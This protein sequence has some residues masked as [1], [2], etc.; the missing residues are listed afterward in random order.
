MAFDQNITYRVNVDDSDFQAKL[1]QLR[2]SLDMTMG[3]SMM[4]GM[5]GMG[6]MGGAGFTGMM[7][8][9]AAFGAMMAPQGGGYGGGSGLADFGSQIRPITYTPP[10][11]AMQPHFGMVAL[12]QTTGQAMFGAMGPLGLGIQ[13][14][15]HFARH[16][17][18]S[19]PD[20]IP[21]NMSMGEYAA[22]ST[23]AFA[24]RMGD[25]VSTAGVVTAGTAASM[26][27]SGLGSAIGGKLIGGF[28]GELIGGMVGGAAVGALVSSTGE[29]MADNRRTQT[30]LEAGSFRFITGGKDADPLTGRGFSRAAR[31]EAAD[32]IQSRELQD[33]R[34][35]MGE[36]SQILESGMQ[37][38][39]FSGSSDLQGFKQ[40]FNGLV[41]SI[42]TVTSTLHTSLKEGMEVIRGFRDIGVTDPGQ[43]SG[44]VLKAETIG[45][46]SGRTGSEML[47]LGQAGAETFRGTGVSMALGMETNMQNVGLV[48][49]MLNMGT[50]NRDTVA[51]A[52][53]ENA[54]A[55]Q[56]TASALAATQSAVGRGA[57]LGMF[58]PATGSLDMNF[59]GGTFGLLGRA[60]SKSPTDI[61]NFQAQEEEIVSKMSPMQL[62]T[63]G[64]Q[65][66]LMQAKTVTDAF[67]GGRRGT[68]EYQQALE[69]QFVN[70]EKR[71]G[72]P[73]AAIRANVGFLHSDPEKIMESQEA[74][75]ASMAQ[76]ASLEDL[77][78]N[79]NIG[80]SIENFMGRTFVQPL[81]RTFTNIG[82]KVAIDIERLGQTMMGATVASPLGAGRASIAAGRA[83]IEASG[84]VEAATRGT[85]LGVIDSSGNMIQR[86]LPGGGQ[87]GEGLA[88]E[89]AD[90]GTEGK[91]VVGPTGQTI[92][93]STYQ[94]MTAMRFK[95]VEDVQ[96][97]NKETGQQMQILSQ[98][99]KGDNPVV[100][101]QT[102]QLDEA[103]RQQDRT[104]STSADRTKAEES[105]LTD[106]QR[107]MVEK[108]HQ[109]RGQKAGFQTLGEALFGKDQFWKDEKTAGFQRAMIERVAKEEGFDVALQ[110]AQGVRSLGGAQIGAAASLFDAAHGELA[111]AKKIL[112]GYHLG[113]SSSGA[114]VTG[115]VLS[116][117]SEAQQL[118]AL[119]M[120]VTDDD[121]QKTLL[122][123]ELRH[124]GVTQSQ[125]DLFD[126]QATASIKGEQRKELDAR[127]KNI[128]LSNALAQD[129]KNEAMG[130]G[131]MMDKVKGFFSTE[132]GAM[133]S[134]SPEQAKQ[135]GDLANQ[136]LE[137]MKLV[138]EL[139]K[140]VRDNMPRR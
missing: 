115:G 4:S 132:S 65:V 134:G 118:T 26:V 120:T 75:M 72:V 49:Q 130:F 68:P 129:K 1:S 69:N 54:L 62:Q 50:I 110:Q 138:V 21:Q 12:Q 104:Q 95:S 45:R 3:G 87:S 74:G 84:G 119:K 35:G 99:G 94:G 5:G 40:K 67:M 98:H 56:L 79:F 114:S 38:D 90:F 139:Q 137:T 20:V 60:A 136:N 24:T 52:G 61:M 63:F 14:A 89:F 29:M 36:M 30:Q 33:K 37:L 19:Q 23:R 39:M 76:Q 42:K 86:W 85:G 47:A 105:V 28:A 106:D 109:G 135:V 27:G 133:G 103:R 58:N 125:L 32:F 44:M 127:L 43:I 78:N 107:V 70:F 13:A 140:Y 48:R 111:A 25:A 55:Q 22:L 66:D 34:F 82:T 77:R 81:Q 15:G 2:A 64:L 8:P 117:M 100:A 121:K 128:D 112:G 116:E 97:F 101:I 126:K 73:I 93:T 6:R 91:A 9:A 31:A 96:K 123:A 11:I 102:K 59:K 53:G 7:P 51:Q 18:S 46:S 80:K 122:R 113:L 41:E 131:G 92:Q 124:S 17:F 57:M 88:K 108:I 10:A 83:A 71:R 16:P